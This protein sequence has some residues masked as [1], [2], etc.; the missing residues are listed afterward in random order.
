MSLMRRGGKESDQKV[1]GQSRL[2]GDNRVLEGQRG[3]SL[4]LARFLLA[5][6][7]KAQPANKVPAIKFLN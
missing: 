4:P 5:M 7:Q 1:R 6:S 2:K 3:F